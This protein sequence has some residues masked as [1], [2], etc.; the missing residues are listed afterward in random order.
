[1][2]ATRP[3]QKWGFSLGATDPT[4]TDA[5][6][7]CSVEEEASQACLSP[8][9]RAEEA[10]APE[11]KKVKCTER[12]PWYSVDPYGQIKFF[13]TVGNELP[14]DFSDLSDLDT[15]PSCGSPSPLEASCEQ[16]RHEPHHRRN[17]SH[18]STATL[19]NSICEEDRSQYFDCL[20]TGLDC[21][22]SPEGLRALDIVANQGHAKKTENFEGFGDTSAPSTE[23][24]YIRNTTVPV[25]GWF[26]SCR[27][28]GSWTATTIEAVEVEIPMCR[29]CHVKWDR[30]VAGGRPVMFTADGRSDLLKRHVD[31]RLDENKEMAASNRRAVCE[32][33]L[34]EVHHAWI[35]HNGE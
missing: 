16:S 23:R 18:A 19:E 15:S 31:N 14:G 3:G 30:V 24:A 11:A 33:A 6:M 34:L 25:C 2:N 35:A 17:Y 4:T 22:R 28:C 5:I 13:G 9:W 8:D 21:R 7:D 29:R 32:T 1:M 27:C 12:E 10:P 26:K 20:S